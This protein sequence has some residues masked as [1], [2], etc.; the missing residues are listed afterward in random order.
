ML[1]YKI[2]LRYE[3]GNSLHSEEVTDSLDP[4][5]ENLDIAKDNLRRIK[6]HYEQYLT[7]NGCSYNRK[8]VNDAL[9]SNMNKDWFVCVMKPFHI[10][11]NH[12]ISEEYKKTLMDGEWENRLDEFMA[13]HTIRLKLDNGNDF[14]MTPYWIGQFESLREAEIIPDN[15]DMKITF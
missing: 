13:E 12:A 14:Q 9:R 3:T 2:S 5:W 6:E 1:K 11:R 15:T 8:N 4:V 10:G 7:L